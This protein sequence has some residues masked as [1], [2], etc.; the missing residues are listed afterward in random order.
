M[1]HFG[2]VSNVLKVSMQTTV[3]ALEPTTICHPKAA[4]PQR[5]TRSRIRQN[6]AQTNRTHAKPYPNHQNWAP[7]NHSCTASE[8][9][10]QA[11]ENHAKV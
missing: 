2:G 11:F 10:H 5:P 7:K 1:H 9:R 3:V 4:L 6:L 8:M